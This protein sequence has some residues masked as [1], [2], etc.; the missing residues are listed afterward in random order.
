MKTPDKHRFSLQWGAETAEKIQADNCLEALGNRKSAFVV[1]AVTDY[2]QAHP[3]IMASGQEI[4]IAV[5]P[6][7]TRAQLESL[8]KA[9]LAEQTTATGTLAQRES[10]TGVGAI[11]DAGLAAML[12]NLDLF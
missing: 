6:S 9:I 3:E 11:D 8:I 2:I 1:M 7:F 4:Q 12:E 5:K 10:D